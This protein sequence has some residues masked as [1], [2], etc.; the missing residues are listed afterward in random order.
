MKYVI[1]THRLTMIQKAH[2]LAL[3]LGLGIISLVVWTWIIPLSVAFVAYGIITSQRR[4][5]DDAQNTTKQ[6]I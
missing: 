3:A 6:D 4:Q 5:E 2:N 1:Q